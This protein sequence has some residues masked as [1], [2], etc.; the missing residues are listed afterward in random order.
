MTPTLAVVKITPKTGLPIRI[1]IN[2]K[3]V[4]SKHISGSARPI[5][6]APLLSNNAIVRLKSPSVRIHL[7]NE[8]SRDLCNEL[9]D[10]LLFIVHEFG[11]ETI[12]NELLK[13]LKVG[14]AMDFQELMQVVKGNAGLQ[15]NASRNDD[16]PL[17]GLE[18]HTTIIERIDK[19]KFTLLFKH[20]WEANIIICDIKRLVKWRKL[21][22]WTAF[23]SNVSG[24]PLLSSQESPH[25]IVRGAVETTEPAAEILQ[26][27]DE[28][29]SSS[30]LI[31]VNDDLAN[32]QDLGDGEQKP[33]V[34]YNYE[35]LINLG[36]GI[37]VH[38]LQRPQRHRRQPLS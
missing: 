31:L 38:V 4:L 15:R 6:E 29:D 37:D 21:L 33:V 11:S 20:N 14:S 8:D 9:R 5:F 17:A 13:K 25:I 3:E 34:E 2:R 36:S 7:S 19:N 12:Q 18:F 26:E 10:E 27:S 22:C 30:R 1:F 16:N 24:I 23:V 32:R 28:E 35:P